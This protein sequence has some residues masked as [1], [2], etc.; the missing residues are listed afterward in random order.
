M[1][2]NDIIYINCSNV[3]SAAALDCGS[4]PVTSYITSLFGGPG[5][6]EP[7]GG[8]VPEGRAG[9]GAGGRAGGGVA[10]GQLAAC[11]LYEFLME[12]VLMGALCVFGVAGNTLS[13]VVLWKDKSR[14]STPFLL[15]SLGGADTLFLAVVFALRVLLSIHL[16]T[17]VS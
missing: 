10:S 17:R 14:S 7:G 3:T 8:V 13:M 6:G 9:G 16:Y 5:E 12:A 2:T 15:V 11:R 4:Q 1:A